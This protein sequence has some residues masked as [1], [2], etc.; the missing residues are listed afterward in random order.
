MSKLLEPMRFPL[1]GNRLIEAS[2]GTGKTYTIASLYLRLLLGHGPDN[3]GYSRALGVDEILV[4]TFTQ[5][6]T[7]ELRDRIRLRIH[8]A[9]LAFIR[10]EDQ[11]PLLQQLL[12]EVA[13][14]RLAARLL[15]AAERQM[16]EAAVFTIHGFCQRMLKQNAFESG[17]LFEAEFVTDE[18]RLRFEAAAD[19]WRAHFYRLEPSLARMVRASFKDPQALLAAVQPYLPNGELKIKTGPEQSLSERHQNIIDAI[20]QLKQAWRRQAEEVAGQLEGHVKGYTGKNFAGWLNKIG[21]W[22]Q[23]PT[24]DYE[25]PGELARFGLGVLLDK[26]SKNGRP[27]TLPLFGQI[28]DFMAMHRDIRDLVLA[29][30]IRVLRTRIKRAKGISGQLTFDDLLANLDEALAADAGPVLAERIR[31][32]FPVAMIDEFQDTDPLQYRIFRR[33]YGDEPRLGLFM[34]GDPKQ[35]IYGFRGADIFTY[36]QARREVEDHYTLGTNWRSTAEMVA[37]TNALFARADA[38]VGAFIYREDISFEPVRAA[39]SKPGLLFR[40]QRQPALGFWLYREADQQVVN[41]GRYQQQQALWTAQEIHALLEA[42]ER[43]EALLEQRPVSAGDIAILVR[44]G[45]EAALVRRALRERGIRSVYLSGRDSVFATREACELLLLL[46]ACLQPGNDRRLRAALATGIVGLTLVELDQLNQDEDAWERLVQEFTDYRRRWQRQGVLPMLRTLLFRRDIPPRLLAFNEGE[47]R[48]T[49]VLHL[50]ELLQQAAQQLDGE[51]ALVRWLGEQIDSPNGEAAEQQLR[52]ES[53]QDLVRVVTIHKSKGLEYPLVY[54]PFICQFKPAGAPLYHQDGRTILD[55]LDEQAGREKADRE[56]LAEDLRLLYV[57]LTRAVYGT[58]IGVAPIKRGNGKKAPTDLHHSGLGYLLQLGREGGG[59]ALDQALS[60]L[61]CEHTALLQPLEP[62]AAS[63]QPAAEAGAAPTALEFDGRI[64]RDWWLTSYSALSRHQGGAGSRLEYLQLDLEVA[65]ERSEGPSAG[66]DIFRFPRGARAGTFLHSVFERL[67]FPEAVGDGLHQLLA[68]SL[69]GNGYET[70]WLPALEQ[71][72]ADVLDTELATGLQLRRLG[73]GQKK[74]EL[75]FFL[76]LAGLDAPQLNRLLQAHDPLAMVAGPLGFERVKGMLKGFI[77]LVF[78]HQGRYYLL[79][80]K[81]NHLGDSPADYGQQALQQAMIEH[82]YD[83]Q[84]LIYTL[85]LHRLLRLRIA[86]YDYERYFGGV[87]YL[88]LRGMKVGANT[89]IFH[90]RPEAALIN[91]LDALF[92]GE[93]S[94]A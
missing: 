89:G 26:L 22:A 59:E 58:R 55:L 73:Q 36:I 61:S 8:Q 44:T 34:I 27:P 60:A 29:H 84:Y 20:E 69:G 68:E 14:H 79:D 11:D 52:L 76:P 92:A 16:D 90:T 49:D 81:S 82:R 10:G 47:R 62:V 9:R 39:R 64:D 30:A 88:F 50:G 42:G 6:A 7:E 28:E 74:V 53:E 78:E 51:H 77:D 94:H 83:L 41:A 24:R 17:T 5:A 35:A 31:Q 54:L 75:E 86:D 80:Y 32:Q 56:R 25:V 40:G 67:D 43:G 19:F 12:D 48:L 37:A 72:V 15:L 1:S 91:G 57:G 45:R 13:D 46:H 3:C 65:G 87:F 2:A 70:H 85:A 21:G 18:Q 93:P 63:Y 66:F 23:A 33:L 38:E 71:L 4:V